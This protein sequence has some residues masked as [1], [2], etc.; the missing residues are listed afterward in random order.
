[1]V[2]EYHTNYRKPFIYKE[3]NKPKNLVLYFLSI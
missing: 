1:M 3:Y 2:P